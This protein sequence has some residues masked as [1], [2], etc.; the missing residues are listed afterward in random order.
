[1]NKDIEIMDLNEKLQYISDIINIFEKDKTVIEDYEEETLKLLEDDSKFVRI[2]ATELSEFSKSIAIVIKL[3][4]L[5]LNDVEAYV[6]G[7]AAKALGEIGN[8]SCKPA[9]EKAIGDSDGFV[10]SFA[11]T[12][13]KG[14]KVKSSFSSNL[15][16]LRA[17]M[18]EVK[19]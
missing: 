10:V 12:A 6:R 9:L 17:R 15:D 11:A 7:F 14:I 4:N 1:M 5:L 3:Q 16:A 19:K 18:K 2:K 13:L 8:I